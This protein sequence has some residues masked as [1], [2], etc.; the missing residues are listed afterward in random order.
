MDT[1]KG[2]E[3]LP[4]SP[5][6]ER[7]ESVIRS[8]ERR[9]GSPTRWNGRVFEEPDANLLG[10]AYP[11]GSMTVSRRNVLTP[12]HLAFTA[13][14]PLTSQQNLQ[15][16]DAAA[17]VAHEAVHLSSH[18]GDPRAPGAYPLQDDAEMALEEGQ[19]EHWTH[20]NLDDVIADI[21]LD[22]AA[23]G[24]LTQPSLDAYP[25]YTQAAVALNRGLAGRAGRTIDDVAT[26][27]I[28]TD[29]TQRWNAVADIMIDAR[30]AGLMPESHRT[31]VR[32]QVVAAAR[33][34]FADL[35]AAQQ[36]TMKEK[37]KAKVGHEAAV[38]ALT[39]MD[40]AIGDAE[41][42]YRGSQQT[43]QQVAPASWQPQAGQGT[44]QTVQPN[45][46]DDIAGLH[47]LMACQAPAAAATS[48][49]PGLSVGARPNR[50]QYGLEQ[51][52]SPERG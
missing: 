4:S 9:T 49:A 24:V 15:A 41:R 51:P 44:G 36:G 5:D 17:T 47:K 2:P 32:Q 8:V 50:H 38:R 26:E 7:I 33:S 39:G 6:Y 45:A 34:A 43:V 11:D 52:R 27:L 1:P 40:Q 20:R 30:L 37:N 29:R 48:R 23:P 14:H 18:F 12:M 46:T 21:G 25:A 22:E 16:R 42:R 31:V 19:A 28:K 10:A 3:L 35:P 13:G